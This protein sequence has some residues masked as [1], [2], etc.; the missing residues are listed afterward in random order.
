MA[1]ASTLHY[2]IERVLSDHVGP[3]PVSG[4]PRS[5]VVVGVAIVP[6]A[7]A[8]PDVYNG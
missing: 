3:F 2:R 5:I 8:S 7:A 4:V 1:R 6:V